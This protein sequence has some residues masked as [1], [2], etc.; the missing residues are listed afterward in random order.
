M[1]IKNDYKPQMLSERPKPAISPENHRIKWVLLFLV[2]LFTA[3]LIQG[4]YLQVVEHPKLAA[5]SNN[6][7]MR[8]ISLMAARGAIHDRNGEDLAISV[9]VD[10]L[11][12]NPEQITQLPD[13]K[14]LAQLSALIGVPTD[15]LRDRL[16]QKNKA[17]VSLKRQLPIETRRQIEALNIPGLAFEK[18]SKRHYLS[19]EVFAHVIGFTN[20]DGVGQ[21]GLESAYEN[22]LHGQDGVK[23]ILR[24]NRG[25]VV[26]SLNS[27]HNRAPQNGSDLFLSL[28][29]RIQSLAY[30]ELNKAMAHYQAK[31]G[32]VVV[33]DAKTGEVLALV[34][35]PTYNPN[36]LNNSDGESRRNR[37]LTDQFELGS[38][39][40]PFAV[41]KALDS[42]KV[43]PQ[44]RLDT[45][46]YFIGSKRISDTH[47]YASLDVSGVIQKSSN[48][49]TSKLSALFR[50]EQMHQFYRAVGF[51]ES[52]KSDFPGETRGKLRD[53]HQWR[54]IDQATM[55]Y[56]YGVQASLLQLA[57]AYTIFTND[58]RLLPVSF[59]KLDNIPK[60]EPI[61][62]EE[63]ARQMRKM[64]AAVTE[65]GGT[66][67]QGAISGFK[68]AG[69]TGTARKLVNGQYAENKHM[70]TFV[71][72]APADNPRVIVA[73]NIDEPSANGYY[74]GVVSGP[75][76]KNVMAG[77]LNLLGVLP[78]MP[79]ANKSRV[80]A[81]R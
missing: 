33:L 73:V 76:F 65:R 15:T 41:A 17:Y 12:A 34:N 2:L 39:M 35:A 42:G 45:R 72:F 44:T 55:S 59:V 37:A 3:L 18:E 49:G 38:V 57:R 28:D 53:W 4:S 75:V 47:D 60:G 14:R 58:G 46:P 25:N 20:I 6:R 68:V 7:V 80:L 56:G 19:G 36:Q 61:T 8:T 1:L 40:K 13:D 32:S 78:D 5:E 29:Q 21:E 54:P 27:V 70:A 9:P 69:K 23:A 62:Q 81:Q 50:P 10:T 24:D 71:G 77:S 63:T 11:Y 66:G 16:S 30:A 51:G 48:V 22:T 74:A 64:L 26:D 67:T 79:A 52:I 31:A 43:F